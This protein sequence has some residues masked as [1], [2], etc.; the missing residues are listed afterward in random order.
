MITK[1]L[2]SLGAVVA[3]EKLIPANLMV[4]GITS[5]SID[6]FLKITLT[7]LMIVLTGIKIKKELQNKNPEK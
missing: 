2:A 1:L 4:L 6:M 3:Q 5:L 7:L